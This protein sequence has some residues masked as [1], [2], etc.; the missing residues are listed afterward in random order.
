MCQKHIFTGPNAT[1]DAFH[2]YLSITYLAHTLSNTLQTY[3][4]RSALPS[5]M[6]FTDVANIPY[7]STTHSQAT[8]FEA[9]HK[10]GW[11]ELAWFLAPE[12]HVCIHMDDVQWGP[13]PD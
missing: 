5:Y 6:Y 7:D 2:S 13:S 11:V 8:P 3:A 1:S 10:L 12:V 4:I 9:A